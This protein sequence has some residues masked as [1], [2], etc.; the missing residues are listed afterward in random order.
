M[1]CFLDFPSLRDFGSRGKIKP[2]QYE[3]STKLLEEKLMDNRELDKHFF[4]FALGK[5]D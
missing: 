4:V 3:L 1:P 2:F 5:K